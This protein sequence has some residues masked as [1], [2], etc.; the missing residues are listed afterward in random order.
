M[1]V[2]KELRFDDS[3]VAPEGVCYIG[4]DRQII[5]SD[6]ELYI[7]SYD[8]EPNTAIIMEPERALGSAYSKALVKFLK[9]EYNFVRFQFPCDVTGG[10]EE[11]D[12]ESM[13]FIA[14]KHV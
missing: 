5:E 12:L 9:T 8:D 4:V 14:T 11:I 1:Q 10:F 6:V 13:Q 3:D 7:R 2:I